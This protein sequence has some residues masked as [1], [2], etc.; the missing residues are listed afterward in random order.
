[1]QLMTPTR[2]ASGAFAACAMAWSCSN[3]D[4]TAIATE[5]PSP[6]ARPAEL[7]LKLEVGN[8]AVGSV[9]AVI[10]G[11]AG[12][13]TQTYTADVSGDAGVISLFVSE[14]P[15]GA[16]YRVQLTAGSCTGSATFEILDSQ[17]TF[18]PVSLY[19]GGES[20]DAGAAG[21]AQIT[22]LLSPPNALTCDAIASMVASSAVQSGPGQRSTV[23]VMLGPGVRLVDTAWLSSST[24]GGAGTLAVDADG[25]AIF[26]CTARGTVLVRARVTARHGDTFCTE[27]GRAVVECAD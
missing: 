22:D 23:E 10:S 20:L 25:K 14:L 6:E 26:E 15:V 8:L 16:G 17:T 2:I 21:S 18:A 19:C 5:Q 13:E 11:G 3:T 1:M 9:T 12:F 7:R 4:L 27:E 24:D